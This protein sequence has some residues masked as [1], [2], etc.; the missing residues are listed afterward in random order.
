MKKC[1]D[2]YSYNPSI[3][4][5]TRSRLSAPMRYLLEHELLKGSI[6]DF[7]CGT[8]SDAHYLKTYH[9]LDIRGYDKYFE[10]YD[11]VYLLL[12]WYDTVTCNFVFDSIADP[13]DY[14]HCKNTLRLLGDDVY[15]SFNINFFS[16][17]DEWEYDYILNGY[18]TGREFKKYHSMQDIKQNFGEFD[19]ISAT[20]S[21]ILIKLL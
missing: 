11:D 3:T 10:A 13:S 8:G 7:G 5:K 17:K 9:N 18:W 1:V 20:K 15:I 14:Q 12:D 4:A 21:Y 6:L 19:V 16:I 2:I